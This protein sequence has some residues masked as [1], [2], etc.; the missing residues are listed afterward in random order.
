MALILYTG[1][2]M[3]FRSIVS[4][5]TVLAALKLILHN[6]FHRREG[7]GRHEDVKIQVFHTSSGR[8]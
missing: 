6:I 8:R 1:V 5:G 7:R 2:P 3:I 4:E